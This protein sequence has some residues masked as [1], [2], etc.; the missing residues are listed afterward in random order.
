MVGSRQGVHFHSEIKFHEYCSIQSGK[1]E[2][3]RAQDQVNKVDV[4]GLPNPIPRQ[5][6]FFKVSDNTLSVTVQYHQFMQFW[7]FFMDCISATP[8][9]NT[10]SLSDQMH[11][12]IFGRCT[13]G[14]VREVPFLLEFS[15][16]SFFLN[17]LGQ[18]KDTIGIVDVVHEPID[19]EQEK[20]YIWPPTDFCYFV[21]EHTVPTHPIL[22]LA[23]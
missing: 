3:L 11:Y 15:H 12:I 22:N 13:L 16:S 2:N 9:Y 14:F 7:S 21:L 5:R 18:H 8:Q 4:E 23:H 20:M 1:G 19:I 6:F 17:Q 10:P